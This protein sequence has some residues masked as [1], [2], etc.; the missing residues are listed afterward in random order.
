MWPE[1]HE[2][3]ARSVRNIEIFNT[4]RMKTPEE[5]GD[6]LHFKSFD[7]EMCSKNNNYGNNFQQRGCHACWKQT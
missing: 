7:N 6:I 3:H 5:R 1:I 4:H 2:K